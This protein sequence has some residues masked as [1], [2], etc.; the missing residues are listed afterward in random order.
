MAHQD[1]CLAV[2]HFE[3]AVDNA[4]NL[5]LLTGRDL[6]ELDDELA[7][8]GRN[9]IVALRETGRRRGPNWLP[10]QSNLESRFMELMESVGRVDFERQVPIEGERWTARVDFLHRPSRTVIEIQSERYHTSLTDHAADA[11]RRSRLEEAGYHVVEVWDSEIFHQP[12]VVVRR[13][14]DA[15]RAIA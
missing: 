13:V 2:Q 3:R 10:P 11:V 14:A 8:Q 4:W 15:V 5:R 1:Y 9:G 6:L 12:A 7:I